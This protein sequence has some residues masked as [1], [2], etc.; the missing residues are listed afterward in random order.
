MKHIIHDWD[1]ERAA[2]SC[3][4]SGASSPERPHG[5]VI[6]LEVGAA[7][8]QPAGPR[9]ADRSRDADDAGRPRTHRK[10][11]SRALFTSAGFELTRVVPTKSPLSVVEALP[12]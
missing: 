3:V 9:Q 8:G 6:L 2:R 12:D 4:T 5:K 7:A 10:R 1:D 11:S